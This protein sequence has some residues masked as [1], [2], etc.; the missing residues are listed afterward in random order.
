MNNNEAILES[1]TSFAEKAH[2]GQ[3]RK[4]TPDRYMVHP[5]RVM[6]ICR[7]FTDDV[8]ILSAA[9]LHDVLEDTAVTKD[10]M[11]SFLRS[12]M[13]EATATKTFRLVVELTDVYIKKD[14][15]AL[16]RRRR[17]D[18]ERERISHTSGDS[19]T[20]KYADIL[21]NCKEIVEHDRDFARVFL[22]ECGM[23]LRVTK[24]GNAELY[25]R[26]VD[27]VNAAMLRLRAPQ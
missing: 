3:T 7:E 23:M 18:L 6:K 11:L 19:Q 24:R 14:Y 8:A 5:I 13:D 25:K 9:L 20:I 12:V 10:H 15:P 26:A 21:D 27:Q 4:Y 1:V 17:K 2:E 22:R 16:N